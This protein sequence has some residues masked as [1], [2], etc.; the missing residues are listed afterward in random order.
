MLVLCR[1]MNY[2]GY[3]NQNHACRRMQGRQIK[4]VLRI[5]LCRMGPLKEVGLINMNCQYF[6]LVLCTG[7]LGKHTYYFIQRLRNHIQRII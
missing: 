3:Y 4:T 2:V 1:I 7:R 5:Q 6:H